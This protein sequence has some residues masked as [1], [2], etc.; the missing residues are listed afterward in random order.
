M[1]E[2]RLGFR[3]L[4]AIPFLLS[5][6][7]AQTPLSFYAGGATNYGVWSGSERVNA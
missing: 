1:F 7:A 6:R 3:L 5:A 4:L 2:W